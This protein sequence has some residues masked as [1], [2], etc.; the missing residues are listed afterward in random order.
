MQTV[1]EMTL[2]REIIDE[3]GHAVVRETSCPGLWLSGGLLLTMSRSPPLLPLVPI[4]TAL[5]TTAHGK[6]VSTVR[7]LVTSCL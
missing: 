4:P 1:L 2:L 6:C 3:L 7:G 5:A